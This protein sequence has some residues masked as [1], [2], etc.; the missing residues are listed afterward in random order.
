MAIINGGLYELA[1]TWGGFQLNPGEWVYMSTATITDNKTI[2]FGPRLHYGAWKCH[3]C[4]MIN[5]STDPNCDHC[6]APGEL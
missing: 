1:K 2:P 6:G 3:Y 5:N 4:A